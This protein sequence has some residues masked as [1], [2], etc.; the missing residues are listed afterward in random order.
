MRDLL[1]ISRSYGRDIMSRHFS[2]IAIAL[3]CHPKMHLHPI[4]QQ[5]MKGQEQQDL[6]MTV[7]GLSDAELAQIG[8]ELKAAQPI[9]DWQ[10]EPGYAWEVIATPNKHKSSYA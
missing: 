1:R 5:K 3:N 10:A 6:I 7:T 2:Y 4:V 8:D 9:Q